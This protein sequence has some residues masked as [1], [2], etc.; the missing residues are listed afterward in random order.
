MLDPAVRDNMTYKID[1]FS[2]KV[3]DKLKAR[4]NGLSK[5]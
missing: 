5:K 1:R 3:L 4:N 2:S